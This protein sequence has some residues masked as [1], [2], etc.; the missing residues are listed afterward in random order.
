M[1]DMR[2]LLY[3]A[4]HKFYSALSHL[5]EFEKGKD[6]FENITHLDVF[7][8]EYRNVT[9]VLQKSLKGSPFIEVYET[10]RD[11]YLVN[12]TGKWFVE[13]RNEVLKQQPFD[14]EKKIAITIYSGEYH[15]TLPERVFTIENDVAYASIIDELQ[16]LFRHINPI[17]VMF[18]A[19]FFFY[20]RG[21]QIELYE[22]F[23][24][25]IDQMRA[26][27]NGLKEAIN[28]TCELCDKLETKIN[29]FN[30]SKIPKNFLFI[31]TTT[32]FFV[33]KAV[34]KKVQD[35]NS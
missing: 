21:E 25:G 34:L 4:L 18:S 33:K 15:L 32:F 29:S 8:S 26:L 10:L 2:G 31:A 20:E 24:S 30:F 23:I 14:L 22:N 27:L 11:K 19:E 1:G 17:E 13:K 12:D 9:F 7:F 16:S 5:E 28:E 35:Q 6:F 3:P